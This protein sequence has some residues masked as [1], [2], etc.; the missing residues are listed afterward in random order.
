MRQFSEM[1]DRRTPARVVWTGDMPKFMHLPRRDLVSL[2]Q[3][4][5]SFE[6]G[7]AFSRITGVVEKERQMRRLVMVVRD[8]RVERMVRAARPRVPCFIMLPLL[9]VKPP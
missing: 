2:S 5:L 7:F 1:S 4:G 8:E 9:F 3:R 6:T